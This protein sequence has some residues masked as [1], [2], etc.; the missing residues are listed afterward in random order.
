M[1]LRGPVKLLLQRPHKK[2]GCRQPSTRRPKKQTGLSR[3]PWSKTLSNGDTHMKRHLRSPHMKRHLRSPHMKRQPTAR[4]PQPAYEQAPVQPA[5]LL[6]HQKAI[7][8]VHVDWA[9]S[10]QALYEPSI[11][12]QYTGAAGQA[13]RGLPSSCLPPA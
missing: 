2:D 6:I 8:P 7:H 3:F 11:N 5:N 1:G 9:R 12:P 10:R 13:P 4:S